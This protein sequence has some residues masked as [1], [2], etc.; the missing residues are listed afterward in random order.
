MTR[1]SRLTIARGGA[2]CG[3]VGATKRPD[4]SGSQP[5]NTPVSASSRVGA[6]S[7]VNSWIVSKIEP[8]DAGLRAAIHFPSGDTVARPGTD[9]IIRYATRGEA[10][11]VLVT[12]M[13][14]PGVALAATE[15]VGDTVGVGAAT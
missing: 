1:P 5:R 10:V 7:I 6:P 8:P 14:G 4:E 9:D 15:A 13:V 12:A 2:R 11:G 3:T